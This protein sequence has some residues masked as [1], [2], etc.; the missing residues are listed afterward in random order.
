MV[1]MR[2]V[3]NLIDFLFFELYCKRL[4]ASCGKI[5]NGELLSVCA[6]R[7]IEYLVKE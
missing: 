4:Q 2:F 5:R 3:G 7:A 1:W 6:D